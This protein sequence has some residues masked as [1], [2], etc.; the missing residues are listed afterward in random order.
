MEGRRKRW[1]GESGGE[2]VRDGEGRVEE[3]RQ[4]MERGEGRREGKQDRVEENGKHGVL[5]DMGAKHYCT[6]SAV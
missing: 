5:V 4:E 3:R 1:R 2:K 6:L